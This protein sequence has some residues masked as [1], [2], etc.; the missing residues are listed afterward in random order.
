MLGALGVLVDL[1]DRGL[2]D[3]EVGVPLEMLGPDLL[4]RIVAGHNHEIASC[5]AVKTMLARTLTSCPEI[6]VDN[7]GEGTQGRDVL[8]AGGLLANG[9]GQACIQAARP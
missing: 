9:S 2:A 4:M 3:V 7:T 1:L 8:S 5:R 6:D